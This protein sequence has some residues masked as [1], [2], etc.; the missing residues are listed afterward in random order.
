MA[1]LSPH[2]MLN[3]PFNKELFEKS[4]RSVTVF[5][6]TYVADEREAMYREEKQL[7]WMCLCFTLIGLMIT[8]IGLFVFVYHDTRQRVK[9]IGIRKVNGAPVASIMWLYS[10]AYKIPL[11]GWISVESLRDE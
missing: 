8:A 1:T 5:K 3:L 10:F 9:E 7:G 11:S 4:N 2:V 6:Y